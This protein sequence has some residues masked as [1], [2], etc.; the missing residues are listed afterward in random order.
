ML[1]GKQLGCGGLT[2]GVP[3]RSILVLISYNIFMNDL[4]TKCNSVLM[5]FIDDRKVGANT[6][7]D[8]SIRKE[9]LNDLEEWS[10]RSRM[11]VQSAR[12]LMLVQ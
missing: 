8:Q 4:A 5:K 12:S 7:E 2:N 1:E 9:E 10:I 11:T 3:P 6:E